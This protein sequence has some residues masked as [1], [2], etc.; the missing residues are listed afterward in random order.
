MGVFRYEAEIAAR[1][2][3]PF[4]TVSAL[5]D[6]GSVYTWVP[7]DLLRDLGLE[8]TDNFEFFMADGGKTRRDAVEAV[9]R[10]EG[11]VRHTM[12][13]F[14]ED[15]DQVLLGA[16]TLAGFALAADPVNKRLVPMAAL[17]AVSSDIE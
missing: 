16:Y 2:Q 10:L 6:T 5:V 13:V 8:P 11:R 4:R 7:G 1:P 17:P 3:G 12:C 14:G 15:D 9:I